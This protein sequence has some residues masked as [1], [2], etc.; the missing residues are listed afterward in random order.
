MIFLD[1]LW[2]ITLFL[3]VPSSIR[4]AC[5]IK[6]SDLEDYNERQKVNKS[7]MMTDVLF[8]IFIWINIFQK[9][10]ERIGG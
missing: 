4:T 5:L 10:I 7:M 3:L 6:K 2:W 1:I 8:L 9:I